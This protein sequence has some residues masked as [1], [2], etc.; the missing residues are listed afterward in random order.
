MT[1]KAKI[2]DAKTG[3]KPTLTQFIIRYLGYFVAV[4]PLG[5]GIFWVAWD[6]KKQ[7]WHDKM[8]GT[9]VVKDVNPL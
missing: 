1:I 6:S 7:G 8:A 4:I 2:V 3:E 5:L 9:L